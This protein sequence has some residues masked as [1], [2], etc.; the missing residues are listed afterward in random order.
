M[1]SQR[2]RIHRDFG[3]GA[4]GQRVGKLQGRVASGEIDGTVSL[5]FMVPVD[6]IIW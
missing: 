3:W 6:K 4:G 1:S 2:H 5:G